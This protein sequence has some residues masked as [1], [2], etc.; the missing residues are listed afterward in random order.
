MSFKPR[1]L[2]DVDGVIANFNK[3]FLSCLLEATGIKKK[4]SDVTMWDLEKVLGLT[5]RQGEQTWNL[6]NLP[7]R[8]FQL[9][10]YPGAVEAIKELDIVTDVYFVTSP[11]PTSPTWS[12]DRDKWLQQ[13]FGLHLGGRVV[14]TH[15][16]HVCTGAYFVD[17]KPSNVVTWNRHHPNKRSF[18]W[19]M[20]W[21]ADFS[22]S[23]HTTPG[24]LPPIRV[25]D[26]G[27]L[28]LMITEGVVP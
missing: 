5:P 13:H 2:I 18:L 4:E 9:E 8:A 12:F 7:G 20:P 14:Y 22:L 26:W 11:V 27:S 21:N 15:Q 10:P 25:G 24:G 3:L 28:F 19:N 6:V 23:E 1:L 16:K 17:D